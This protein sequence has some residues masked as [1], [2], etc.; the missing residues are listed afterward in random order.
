MLSMRD[1]EFIIDKVDLKPAH[2]L[3]M[4]RKK[5]LNEKIINN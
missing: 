2:D 1:D 3:S 4:A 5:T